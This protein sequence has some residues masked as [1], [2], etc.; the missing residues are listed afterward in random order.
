M[1]NRQLN[2]DVKRLLKAHR[3]RR[4]EFQKGNVD[5]GWEIEKEIQSEI[6]RLYYADTKLEYISKNNLLIMLRLNLRY[7]AITLHHFGN[8]IDL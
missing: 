1:T 3:E 8:A 2:R 7:R 6:R 4:R 5:K